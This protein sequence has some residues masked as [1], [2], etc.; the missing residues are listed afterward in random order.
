MTSPLESRPLRVVVL[1]RVSTGGQLEGYGLDV[2]ERDCRNYAHV[3]NMRIV[4]I[5]RDEA[6]TGKAGDDERP[7]LSEA[8]QI[9]AEGKADALLA[10]NLDRLARHLTQQ[11]AILSVVW[12]HG[13]RV[14]TTDRGEHLPDDDDDPMRT[15]VRQVMGA[16]AQL[17]RGLIVKRLKSGRR[18]KAE[19]GGYAT[20]SPPYGQRA[21]DGELVEHPEEAAVLRQIR[22]WATEGVGVRA[23]ARRLNDAGI[24]SKRG[25]RWHPST[26]ARQVDPQARADSRRRSAAVR[27]ADRERERLA[28]ASRVL[29]RVT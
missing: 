26:V 3:H 2:Q 13:K 25:G 6:I 22:V 29:G 9:L 24:P 14:F 23:I 18:Q 4:K 12:A 27:A 11:E 28:R 8:L 1:V 20:G 10:P 19:S 7:G 17:E 5:C 16:A 21:I 15:F